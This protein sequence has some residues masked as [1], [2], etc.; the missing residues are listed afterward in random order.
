MVVSSRA[1]ASC[2]CAENPLIPAVQFSRTTSKDE[3]L[4]KLTAAI[5]ALANSLDIN[6]LAEGVET[7]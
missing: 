4:Q 6:V 2:C 3:K 1:A 7:Q 5:I